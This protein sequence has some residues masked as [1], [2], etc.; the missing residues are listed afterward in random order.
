MRA[1]SLRAAVG[2]A[3]LEGVEKAPV[4]ASEKAGA[5]AGKAAEKLLAGHPDEEKA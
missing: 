1:S 4:K 5:K 3:L 2:V